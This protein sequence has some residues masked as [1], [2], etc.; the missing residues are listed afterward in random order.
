MGALHHLSLSPANSAAWQEFLAALD[1]GDSVVVLDRAARELQ[2]DGTCIAGHPGVR[3][4]LP[5]CER[6]EELPEL[7]SGLIEIEAR[8]WWQLIVTHAVLLEWS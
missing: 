6:G 2:R 7:Q 5:A 1:D 8:D 3:W 4:L